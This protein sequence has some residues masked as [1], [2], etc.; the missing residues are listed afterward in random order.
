MA[1]A[2]KVTGLTCDDGVQQAARRV[3]GVRTDELRDLRALVV[4]AGDALA[5]HDVRI[6]AKRLRYS[7]E[8]FDFCF[9]ETNVEELADT[10]R[11]LQDV[12]GRVHDLD[13]LVDLLLQRIG[14]LDLVQQ[15]AALAIVREQPAELRGERLRGLLGDPEE[16]RSRTGLYQ[17]VASKLDERDQRYAEFEA[18]WD[19]WERS[20]LFERIAAMVDRPLEGVG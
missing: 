11:A 14:R 12:L 13:V 1:K 5:L 10:V 9:P 20:G 18:L 3:I 7:L 6:A 8:I 4:A 16:L 19:E 2:R 17:V 15:Q